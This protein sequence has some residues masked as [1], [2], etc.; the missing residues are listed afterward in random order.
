M[1]TEAPELASWALVEAK[2]E[3]GSGKRFSAAILS[4][5]VWTR[6][7][8]RFGNFL[9]PGWLDPVWRLKIR[10]LADVFAY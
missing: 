5:S 10:H 9:K 6:V 8:N 7:R 3:A 4:T 2:N 1:D